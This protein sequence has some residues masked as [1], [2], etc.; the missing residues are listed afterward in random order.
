MAIYKIDWKKK[1]ALNYA[2]LASVIM[3]LFYFII[4]PTNQE[5]TA[6]NVRIKQKRID[7]EERYYRAKN[8]SRYMKNLKKIQPKMN[9][10]DEIFISRNY[11]LEFI[12]TLEKEANDNQ[13]SQKISLNPPPENQNQSGLQLNARGAFKNL[14]KY[15]ISLESLNYYININLLELTLAGG[16]EKNNEK[17]VSRPINLYISAD[18]YWK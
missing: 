14:L 9:L 6:L 17:N 13:I 11:E 12:T 5:I 2:A 10:L 3:L 8:L 18:T 1:I 16:E 15:L 7:L 4:I